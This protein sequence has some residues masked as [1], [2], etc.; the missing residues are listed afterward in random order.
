MSVA[1][2]QQRNN[3]MVPPRNNYPSNDTGFSQ[4]TRQQNNEAGFSQSTRQ[5]N[6]DAGFFQWT[7]QQNYQQAE[8]DVQERESV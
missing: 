5:Q 8:W 3:A 1:F 6:N 7:R 4:W 2:K